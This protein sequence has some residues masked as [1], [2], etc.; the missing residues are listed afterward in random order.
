MPTKVSMLAC[1]L[2]RD[3][4]MELLRL[5]ITFEREHPDAVVL[6]SARSTDTSAEDVEQMLTDHGLTPT[7]GTEH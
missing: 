1:E 4:A 2:N 7:I 5:L 6:I 3:A